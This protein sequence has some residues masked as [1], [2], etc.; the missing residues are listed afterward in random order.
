MSFT[1]RKTSSL[2]WTTSEEI[3]LCKAWCDVSV[4]KVNTLNLKGFWSEVLACFENEMGEKIRR[5]DAVALKWKQSL[6]PKIAKFSVVYE[7]VK[8]RD[9]NGS[10]DLV[11]F[12]NALAKYETQYGQAFT[13]EPC[14]RILKNCPV[15]TELEMPSFNLE[16]VGSSFPRVILIGSISVEVLVAPEVGAAAVASPAGVL[17][18]DTHSSSEADPSESSLPP[19]S[20]APMVEEQRCI[21]VIITYYFYSKDPYCSHSTH[22]I[23]CSP[24][25]DII[26]LVDAPPE[27][28]R[29]RAILIRPGQDIPIGRLYR[30]HPGG[31]CRA[32]TARKSVIPLPSH[33]LALRHTSHHLDRFTSGS[34]SGHSS[35]DHSSSGHSIL[36]HSLSGHTPPDTTVADSSAPP[37]FVYPPLARTPRCS[38]AYRRW[39]SAPLSTM[40]PPTTS[41]SSAGDS[42]S[43]SSAGPS[44]KRCRSLAA[45]M[46]SSIHALRALVP[47]R[48][49]L[50]PPTN[51][52]REIRDSSRA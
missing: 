15:W 21:T 45:T 33:C 44:Q 48:A 27:I 38:E 29:R 46:T 20:I 19:V 52:D 43:E 24:S 3:A 12:Q 41:E 11:V 26:S 25:T 32:L 36:G 7:R 50:L 28:H 22:T 37:R 39:R 40:Y 49:D 13:L 51:G 34:S 4:N 2:P 17:E 5:Y 42:S 1:S 35:S 47:S 23:Y 18:L 6:R 10:S 8:Q 9:E 14:W 30:T 31:P 16:S